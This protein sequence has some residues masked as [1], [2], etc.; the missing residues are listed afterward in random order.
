MEITVVCGACDQAGPIEAS[1]ITDDLI[2]LAC[3][4]DDLDVF[5]ASISYTH[6]CDV[7]GDDLFDG[8][9][10]GSNKPLW[11]HR[12]GVPARDHVPRAVKKEGALES[13]GT[14]PS[15]LTEHDD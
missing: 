3:G 4:S 10:E 2:C 7:C 9:E 8:S 15:L 5:E 14:L 12:G 6:R 1:K 11:M 13:E